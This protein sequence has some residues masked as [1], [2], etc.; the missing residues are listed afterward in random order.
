MSTLRPAVATRYRFISRGQHDIDPS[1]ISVEGLLV[2]GPRHYNLYAPHTCD[3]RYFPASP[4]SSLVSLR[5]ILIWH[6]LFRSSPLKR[7]RLCASFRAQKP[8]RVSLFALLNMLFLFLLTHGWWLS[9]AHNTTV[10]P[11]VSWLCSAKMITQEPYPLLLPLFSVWM[12]LIM[13][14]KKFPYSSHIL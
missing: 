1:D 9:F 13:R 6:L 5:I 11:P 14:K 2:S 8:Q 3:S 10:F 12:H 4:P 7:S